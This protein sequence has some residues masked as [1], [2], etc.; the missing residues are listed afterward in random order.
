MIVGDA[1]VWLDQFTTLDDR[2]LERI[3]AIWPACIAPLGPQ[4]LEDAVT[5]ALVDRLSADPIVREICYFIAY[6][7]EPFGLFTDGT[8]Y[9]KGKIDLAVLFDWERERYL[10]YECKRLNVRTASG[11][12]SLATD[13]VVDGMM[14]FITEQYAQE[15]PVGCML[16][17]VIDGDLSFAEQRVTTAI[18][19]HAP[20]ALQSGPTLRAA[21]G[22]H[23][24]FETQHRRSS[25][26]AIDLRHA[27]LGCA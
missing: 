3:A 9:S 4:P 25:G 21:L 11:R 5:I 14:R 6:Q 12:A 10:A 20:L 23:L 13:Y 27:L 7:H 17:Y 26:V 8:K 18:M 2:I 1:Q 24:R 15:L 22:A 19:A 16:G